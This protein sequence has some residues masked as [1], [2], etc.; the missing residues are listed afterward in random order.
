MSSVEVAKARKPA[1]AADL[2]IVAWAPTR[3]ASVAEAVK[4][5]TD[6]MARVRMRSRASLFRREVP[7]T[8]DDE[9][10]AG[11][12]GTVIAHLRSNWQIPLSAEVSA[13]PCGLSLVCAMVDLGAIVPVGPIPKS[14]SA[15]RAHCLR[16]GDRWC[17]TARIDI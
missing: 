5:L 17:C 16:S 9:L 8:D 13:S 3:E 10:L 2:Q 14:V 1:H 7:G 11:V 6:S 12:L 4:A 15:G